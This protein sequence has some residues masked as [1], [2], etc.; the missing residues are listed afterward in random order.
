VY[1]DTDYTWLI[2]AGSVVV[3]FIFGAL[4][5]S[6]AEIKGY[7][8]I[9]HFWLGF[10]LNVI[11]LL[12]VVGL[13]VKTV[14]RQ[15]ANKKPIE[16]DIFDEP[17]QKP[18]DPL[19][20]KWQSGKYPAG[21]VSLRLTYMSEGIEEFKSRVKRLLEIGYSEADLYACCVDEGMKLWL[22]S[23]IEEQ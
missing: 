12:Y 8:A 18:Q 2:I 5:L 23:A 19:K 21:L 3:A 7:K 6:L 9:P 16:P 15:L 20:V 4:C 10:F 1:G 22:V 17:S 11:G 13:P 14:P